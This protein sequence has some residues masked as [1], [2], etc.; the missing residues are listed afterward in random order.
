[1]PELPE[2]EILRRGLTK[3][4]TGLTISGVNIRFAKIFSGKDNQYLEVSEF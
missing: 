2:V 3:Y 1:M 4:L